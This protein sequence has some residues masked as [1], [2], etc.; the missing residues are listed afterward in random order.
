[1]MFLLETTKVSNFLKY[2]EYRDKR[3]PIKRRS[4]EPMRHSESQ[5]GLQVSESQ[6][7]L[8]VP[9]SPQKPQQPMDSTKSVQQDTVNAEQPQIPRKPVKPGGFGAL[10]KPPVLT[11]KEKKL[12]AEIQQLKEQVLDYQQLLEEGSAFIADLSQENEMLKKEV[13][14]LT[15]Q[16]KEKD[17]TKQNQAKD[18]KGEQ[19]IVDEID[20]LLAL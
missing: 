20:D 7:G 18:N 10:P 19:T 15:N 4:T 17:L 12:K 8:Q 5:K 3:E 1:M 2:I 6:K 11:E 9:D 14:K 13:A 16:L